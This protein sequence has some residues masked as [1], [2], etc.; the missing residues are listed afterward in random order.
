M[1]TFVS[2]A[3][4]LNGANAA[5]GA[6]YSHN[7]S[8]ASSAHSVPPSVFLPYRQ[9]ASSSLQDLPKQKPHG[10]HICFSIRNPVSLS[11]SADHR[12]TP[13]INRLTYRAGLQSAMPCR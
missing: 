5:N 3:I 11:H 2:V 12:Y 13:D 10:L 8:S 9:D 6:N 4:S 7:Q 1:V